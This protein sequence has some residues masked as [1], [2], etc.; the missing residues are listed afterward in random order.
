MIRNQPYYSCPVVN[1][2]GSTV[3]RELRLKNKTDCSIVAHV[4][5]EYRQ[6]GV[7]LVY[8]SKVCMCACMYVCI[9]VCN[10][11]FTYL[12]CVLWIYTR[13]MQ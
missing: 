10:L 7:V 1:T 8:L 5:E 13:D 6:H 12:F 9:G 2:S 3:Y 4:K 11:V